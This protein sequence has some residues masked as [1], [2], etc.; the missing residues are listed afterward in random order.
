LRVRTGRRP[1][2]H[3]GVDPSAGRRHRLR[4]AGVGYRLGDGREFVEATSDSAFFDK[5]VKFLL[6]DIAVVNNVNSITRTST[7]TSTR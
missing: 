5:T 6:P 4:R 3:G 7:P 2:T 1:H